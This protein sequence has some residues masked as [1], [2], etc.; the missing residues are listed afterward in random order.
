MAR[1]GAVAPTGPVLRRFLRERGI[2]AYKVPDRFETL[3]ALA[4]T[5]V[6]KVDRAHPAAAPAAPAD[7]EPRT[8]PWSPR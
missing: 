5:A 8:Q 7:P 6:G 4:T 3:E 2:A 1:P